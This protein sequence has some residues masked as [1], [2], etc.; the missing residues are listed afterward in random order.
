MDSTDDDTP[1]S[2]VTIRKGTI[3]RPRSAGRFSLDEL[4]RSLGWSTNDFDEIRVRPF[5]TSIFKPASYQNQ[6]ES[7]LKTVRDLIVTKYPRLND[8]AKAWPVKCMLIGILK[9]A[10]EAAKQA[11]PSDLTSAARRRRR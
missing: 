7:A 8:Y 2:G 6:S 10:S 5:W 11:G 9:R 4:K 3:A 1:N